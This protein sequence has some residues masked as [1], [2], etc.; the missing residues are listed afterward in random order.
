MGVAWF[1]WVAVMLVVGGAA[2]WLAVRLRRHWRRP[3]GAGTEFGACGTPCR[4]CPFGADCAGPPARPD[5]ARRPH[6]G[7]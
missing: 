2:G 5:P 3:R 6:D 4:D 7:R 1:D